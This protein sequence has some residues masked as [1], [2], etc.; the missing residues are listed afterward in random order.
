MREIRTFG[1][2]GGPAAQAAGLSRSLQQPPAYFARFPE[3]T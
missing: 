2:E 1:S 3:A